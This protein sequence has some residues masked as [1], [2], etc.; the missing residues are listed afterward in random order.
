MAQM[1]IRATRVVRG[2]VVIPVADHTRG[3]GQQRDQRETN[4]ED[5]DGFRHGRILEPGPGTPL[6]LQ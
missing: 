3:K 5:A 6:L 4:T 1:A 2:I